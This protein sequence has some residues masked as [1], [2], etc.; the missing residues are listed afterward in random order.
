MKK[1][2]RVLFVSLIRFIVSLVSIKASNFL[3]Q[4]SYVKALLSNRLSFLLFFL[5][6]P[7]VFLF[8]FLGLYI[9]SLFVLLVLWGYFASIVLVRMNFVFYGKL[10]TF[11]NSN[12][13]I[14]YF[15]FFLGE[16][17][18][19]YMAF[20][21]L[22]CM[23]IL[24][25][26]KQDRLSYF[27]PLFTMVLFFF[28]KYIYTQTS[29][30]N[31]FYFDHFY[32]TVIYVS[33]VFATFI[34][35]LFSVRFFKQGVEDVNQEVMRANFILLNQKKKLKIVDAGK[36]VQELMLPQSLPV[37]PSFL[38]SVFYRANMSVSGDF[39]FIKQ[40]TDNS[41]ICFIADCA[42]KGVPA[43]LNFVLLYKILKDL[44][45]KKSLSECANPKEMM[46]DLQKLLFLEPAF[47]KQVPSFYAVL[48]GDAHEM[49][50]VNAGMEAL[51]IMRNDN[52]IFL[53]NDNPPLRAEIDD[54]F[55]SKKISLEE[56]DVI[57]LFTDCLTSPLKGDQPS[58][59]LGTSDYPFYDVFLLKEVIKEYSSESGVNLATYIANYFVSYVK[60]ID[61]LPDDITILTIQVMGK[62]KPSFKT[63]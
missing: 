58:F 60:E 56:N 53:Q 32:L 49:H 46:M 24:L 12:F 37:F 9:P 19:I 59:I 50:Y 15:S 47:Q 23:P 21:G 28:V 3:S 1:L 42:G 55:I 4:D 29:V 52:S 61:C 33:A 18:G 45:D 51:F 22:S 27:L 57:C 44:I 40:I 54:I 25:L 38:P 16:E 39:Y 2:L 30:S 11:L 43:A 8:A 13:A 41:F 6:A 26:D 63:V 10:I 62:N 36:V 31:D 20:F 7:Y 48:D 34:I 17:S 35:I 14:L 5:S